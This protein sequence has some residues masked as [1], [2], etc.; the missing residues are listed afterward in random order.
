MEKK[1]DGIRSGGKKGVLCMALLIAVLTAAGLPA[2]AADDSDA[3]GT[4]YEVT[5]D[6]EMKEAADAGSAAVCELKAGTAVIVE[7]ADGVWSRVL[8]REQEGYVA[9]DDLTIYAEDELENLAQEMNGVAE[10]EERFVEEAELSAKQRRTSLI[11]GAV[12]AILVLA[13]FWFSVT[14]A[15]R[16]AKEDDEEE[17]AAT[18]IDGLIIEDMDTEKETGEMADEADGKESFRK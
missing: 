12:I 6:T 7:S 15:V 14:A 4:L 16:N 5:V 10:G 11:W 18:E 17:T 9:S 13:I 3:V 8:Y 1:R 2:Y